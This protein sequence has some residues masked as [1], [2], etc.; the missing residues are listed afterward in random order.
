MH[1]ERGFVWSMVWSVLRCI[2]A[3]VHAI[4]SLRQ[5]R[6]PLPMPEHRAAVRRFPTRLPKCRGR[7][8]TLVEV[9]AQVLP[10]RRHSAP[11]MPRFVPKVVS[12][13]VEPGQQVTAGTRFVVVRMPEVVRAAGAYLAAAAARRQQQ[14][15]SLPRRG[16]ATFGRA[17]T[18]TSLSERAPPK[19]RCCRRYRQPVCRLKMLPRPMVRGRVTA[20]QSHRVVIRSPRRDRSNHVEPAAVQPLCASPAADHIEAHLPILD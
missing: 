11:V 13:Q 19:K 15:Q 3:V 6:L 7:S 17:E 16:L 14:L 20:P 2:L 18:A 9:P 5:P 10:D 8:A 1:H 12:V 4:R